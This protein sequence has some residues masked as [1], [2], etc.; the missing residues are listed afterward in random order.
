VLSDTVTSP[1]CWDFCAGEQEQYPRQSVQSHFIGGTHGSLSLPDLALWT[2]RGE[3][4]WHAE[5]TREQTSLHKAD[6][7][8][9]AAAALCGRDCVR[10]EAPLC[11]ALDGL[12]T[13]QATLAVSEAA[14][15]GSPVELPLTG[16]DPMN[17]V[18]DRTLAI[19]ELLSRHGDGLELASIADQLEHSTQCVHR[20]LADLVRCGY[21]RQMREPWR[22]HAHHQAGVDGPVLT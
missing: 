7:Y 18:L 16:G 8:T 14:A 19:L 5:M 20:L 6:P 17:G 1:W 21:V 2:Y 4:S 10:R 9:A 3:R 22:L 13:L 15:T 11:S 12:R